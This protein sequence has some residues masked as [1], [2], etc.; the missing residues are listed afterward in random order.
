MILKKVNNIFVLDNIP[1]DAYDQ[2]M[3]CYIEDAINTLFID[4]AYIDDE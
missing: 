2:G 4:N 3:F 1:E